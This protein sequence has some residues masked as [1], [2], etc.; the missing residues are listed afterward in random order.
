MEVRYKEGF[1]CLSVTV[2]GEW[3]F[4]E[5]QAE[6]EAM[7]AVADKRGQRRILVDVRDMSPQT[8]YASRFSTGEYIA[9]LFPEPFR[10]AVIDSPEFVDGIVEN[11]AVNRGACF[12]AFSE[13]KAALEWLLQGSN[14]REAGQ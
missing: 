7:R 9:R 6:M 10:V 1:G 8:S 11:V 4:E 13:E 2:C 12:A 14:G 3:D 5:A